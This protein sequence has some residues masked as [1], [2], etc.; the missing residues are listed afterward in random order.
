MA[1]P[2]DF[3]DS[4]LGAQFSNTYTIGGQGAG[5]PVLTIDPDQLHAIDDLSTVLLGSS[6]TGIAS[7]LADLSRQVALDH[8]VGRDGL[9]LL[10]LQRMVESL[11]SGQTDIS[12]GV[13]TPASDKAA[14]DPL[15]LPV[16][17]SGEAFVDVPEDGFGDLLGIGAAAQDPRSLLERQTAD[18]TSL[19]ELM[20][21]GAA[22]GR[23]PELLEGLAD[24][25]A[26]AWA[27]RSV[28]DAAAVQAALA[29]VSTD[30]ALAGLVASGTR[31]MLDGTAVA[32]PFALDYDG[33][34]FSVDLNEL[35]IAEEKRR[36]R[37][38]G[39]DSAAAEYR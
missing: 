7:W 39:R 2:L 24:A 38:L 17:R 3:G 22:G 16:L 29:A 8:P 10:G 25:I 13:V 21:I 26:R 37:R 30:F 35:L 34:T 27:E 11:R 12:K 28:N 9:A 14:V 5:S 19:P 31:S 18:L 32:S 4:I 33:T 20:G 6:D 1:L 15:Q 23:L 36:S